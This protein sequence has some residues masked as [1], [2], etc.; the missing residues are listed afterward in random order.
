MTTGVMFGQIWIATAQTL[1]LTSPQDLVFMA[2]IRSITASTETSLPS[3]LRALLPEVGS[4]LGTVV[5]TVSEGAGLVTG[6]L[7]TRKTQSSYRRDTRRLLSRAR[8][9]YRRALIHLAE[10]R[11]GKK[12]SG[13][14]L[15]TRHWCR[16]EPVRPRRVRI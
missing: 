7:V 16:H 12:A 5:R 9:T 11:Q 2:S 3:T 4:I 14:G 13:L 8:L 10:C 15:T 1:L 6:A